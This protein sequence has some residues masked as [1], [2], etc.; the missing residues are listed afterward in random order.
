MLAVPALP[1]AEWPPP[2]P[3]GL[4]PW[5]KN[6]L[7]HPLPCCA[8]P[9]HG[10]SHQTSGL[11]TGAPKADG[12]ASDYH[13]PNSPGK[14]GI[15]LGLRHRAAL[16]FGTCRVAANLQAQRCAATSSRIS[17]GPFWCLFLAWL[18]QRGMHRE[19][20]TLLSKLDQVA[21]SDAVTA[22]L[23]GLTWHPSQDALG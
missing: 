18:G 9:G 7:W 2:T 8:F 4:V 20:K 23:A 14:E 19:V 21:S 10:A 17:S 13:Q 16:T 6:Q 22:I 15:W 3:G 11:T 1:M 5:L 12:W